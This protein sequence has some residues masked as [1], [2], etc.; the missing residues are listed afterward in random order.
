MSDD[1]QNNPS[2]EDYV[3]GLFQ[4][5]KTEDNFK[6]DETNFCADFS[7]MTLADE[8]L[9]FFIMFNIPKRA[10][11]HLLDILRR[12][13]I[14]GPRSMY[15]LRKNARSHEYSVVNMSNGNFSYLSIKSNITFLLENNLLS[16][17]KLMY[18][19]NARII[20]LLI[21]VDGLP[22]FKSSPV[23]LWPILML[24]SGFN[25]PLPI[26]VFC[27]IGKPNL[28][29]FIN[30]LSSELLD[31]KQNGFLYDS[32]T[33]KVRNIT[34]TCDTPARCFLQCIKSFSGYFGCGY[35]RQKGLHYKNRIIFEETNFI[36]RT[37]DA[38]SK[39]TENNQLSVSPLSVA[40]SLYSGF[41]PDYMHLICLGV[42]RR[43]CGYYFSYSDKYGPRKPC[44]LSR[45]T[46]NELSLL[47]DSIKKYIPCEFQ[48]KP[49]S[50]SQLEYFKASEYR[51]LLVYIGPFL[52]KKF[53]LSEY[54][55]HF[56]HLH[57][58]VHV[59]VSRRHCKLL[60]TAHRCIE[61]F[62][63]KMSHL[64]GRDSMVYNVHVLLHL[65]EFVKMYG[66]LDNFSCFP[67]E[68]HLYLL[69]RR[70]KQTSG[71]F[72][73]SINRLIEIRGTFV[74]TTSSELFF[75]AK[76]PNN[77]AVIGDVYIIVDNVSCDSLLS[78]YV[79][80]FYKD[81]YS[82]PYSSSL[83]GIGYFELSSTRLNC[84]EA[85]NKAICIPINNNKFVVI[86]FA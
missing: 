13:N 24:I 48:R 60:E 15:H 76:S 6:A 77:C 23:C 37:D 55:N 58:A 79:L 11:Q 20:D 1:W 63:H 7:N 22:L 16:F 47:I 59:F 43:L 86:P 73:Q 34:F 82:V 53:L 75:S 17:Q 46:I 80:H 33:F 5:C 69:K 42:M 41:P 4:D 30:M 12:H 81:L 9:L 39:F 65:Y 19:S 61:I 27:G 35:C 51:S 2:F 26:A 78:G 85:T 10:M 29:S 70:V 21:N 32:L 8:L 54:Y 84:V 25:K 52:F 66:V 71:V 72:K 56:L 74:S 40:V 57:F 68:N 14:D 38:Y 49:R 44:R 83:L 50:V 64:F 67:F 45:N 18:E 28:E 31:L 62:V 36:L 3:D